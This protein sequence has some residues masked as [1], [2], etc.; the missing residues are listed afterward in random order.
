MATEGSLEIAPVLHEFVA[1]RLTPDSG[2]SAADFWA[3]LEAIL[4]DLGPRNL[5]LIHI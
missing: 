4:A 3:A 2:V 1:N 5:S